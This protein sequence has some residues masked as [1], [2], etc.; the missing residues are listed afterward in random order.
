MLLAASMP[1][2]LQSQQPS[3]IQGQLVSVTVVDMSTE[4][5]AMGRLQCRIN[6]CLSLSSSS[7]SSHSGSPLYAVGR[8]D[9]IRHSKFYSCEFHCCNS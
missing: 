3:A 9:I 5:V 7:R 8:E 6:Y 1:I 4:I 2:W